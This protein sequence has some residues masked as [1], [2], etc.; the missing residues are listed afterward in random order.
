[1][2]LQSAN[3]VCEDCRA[4]FIAL[5]VEEY[6]H[7]MELSNK[8]RREL[9]DEDRPSNQAYLLGRMANLAGKLEIILEIMKNPAIPTLLWRFNHKT[10]F[11]PVCRAFFTV[12]LV[13][14]EAEVHRLADKVG[15][16]RPDRIA[17]SE[18]HSIFLGRI[19]KVTG[20]LELLS[21]LVA[22]IDPLSDFH[23]VVSCPD[24]QRP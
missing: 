6:E 21:K 3:G 1:M 13:S 17:P 8:T 11:C 19:A 23:T 9:L 22:R 5:L 20:K 16:E 12:I 24:L 15:R 14:K 4:D 10:N 2:A 18:D 7:A